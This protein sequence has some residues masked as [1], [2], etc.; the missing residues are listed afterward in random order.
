M[1]YTLADQR[2]IT[3]AKVILTVALVAAVIVGGVIV[4]QAQ[5]DDTKEPEAQTAQPSTENTEDPGAIAENERSGTFVGVPPKTGAGSVTLSKGSDG[6]YIVEMDDNFSVQEGPD[7]YVSF[8][9]DGTVDHDTLFSKLESFNGA[10]AH[11]VPGNIDVAKYSQVIIYCKEFSVVF[12]VA[13]LT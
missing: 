6:S 2:G 10:Q 8:G 12:S 4:W 1:S 9:N 5:D 13:D 11:K 7:L 3:V